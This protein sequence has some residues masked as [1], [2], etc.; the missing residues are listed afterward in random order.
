MLI[1][2]RKI[3]SATLVAVSLVGVASAAEDTSAVVSQTTVRFAD[4]NLERS[5][6]V[7][8]LYA[9]LKRASRDVCKD[10]WGTEVSYAIRRRQCENE[11]IARALEDVRHPS[12]RFARA[13]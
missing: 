8:T 10:V 9:R 6:D 4:L 2:T 1:H 3:L 13:R 5:E 12:L 7:Q 11:A